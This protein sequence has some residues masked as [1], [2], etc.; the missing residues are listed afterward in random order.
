[1]LVNYNCARVSSLLDFIV[2]DYKN[3]KKKMREKSCKYYLNIFET[4]N[5]TL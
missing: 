2:I 5:F 3:D 1:M 4:T